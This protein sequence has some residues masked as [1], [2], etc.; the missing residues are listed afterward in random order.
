[1]YAP[2]V[3]IVV[4]GLKADTRTSIAVTEEEGKAMAKIVGAFAYV[5]CSAKTRDG[6]DQVF[7]EV[8]RA[9][10][11]RHYQSKRNCILI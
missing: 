4:V 9:V 8:A 6:I 3:P 11:S 10:W 1:M 2:H 7:E 5:E